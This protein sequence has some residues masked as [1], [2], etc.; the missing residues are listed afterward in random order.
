MGL[1]QS[2]Q[3]SQTRVRSVKSSTDCWYQ[4]TVIWRFYFEINLLKTRLKKWKQLFPKYSWDHKRKKEKNIKRMEI[5]FLFLEL[6][7]KRLIWLALR[8]KQSSRIESGRD[9]A[10]E[11][12]HIFRRGCFAWPPLGTCYFFHNL[13]FDR[14]FILIA[15]QGLPFQESP[16]PKEV[17]YV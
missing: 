1:I 10:G 13:N 2:L 3:L 6:G 14:M 11:L 4:L 16:I 15:E 8:R 7:R 9:G 12:P 17:L 5:I